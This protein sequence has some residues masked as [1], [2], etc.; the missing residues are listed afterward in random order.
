[1]LKEIFR[2]KREEE[3]VEKVQRR[4]F[5]IVIPHFALVGRLNI[6]ERA[7]VRSNDCNSHCGNEI[8]GSITRR[9]LTKILVLKAGSV[10]CN[11]LSQLKPQF[12]DG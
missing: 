8:L 9:N 5:V 2:F 10:P 1:V 6:K 12:V 4:I 3:A 11:Q 7:E